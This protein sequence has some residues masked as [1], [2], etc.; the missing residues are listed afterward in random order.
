VFENVIS[1]KIQNI[2]YIDMSIKESMM[3]PAKDAEVTA[4]ATPDR[5][6]YD[7][8]RQDPGTFNPNCAG[9][10]FGDYLLHEVGT[11]FPVDQFF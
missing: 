1:A 4:D 5:I 7:T 11:F 6:G 9:S 10:G 8:Y 3:F 2:S